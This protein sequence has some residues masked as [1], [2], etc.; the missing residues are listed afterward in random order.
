MRL[1][2][3]ES[4]R[5]RCPFCGQPFGRPGEVD[6]KSETDFYKWLCSC[7]AVGVYDVTGN[8]LGEALLEAIAFACDGDWEK[9]FAMEAE[10]DY[11]VRYLNG[12][13]AREHRVLRVRTSY[14]SG[15]A[16][17]VFVKLL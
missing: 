11:E 1:V 14:K 10:K 2:N 16:A 4:E 7:G 17:F 5:P 13:S 15:L 9:V 8:N 3:R 12:Y 6:P